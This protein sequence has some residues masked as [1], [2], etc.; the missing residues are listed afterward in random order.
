MYD[1]VD[2]KL[3][4]TH[5]T[6]TEGRSL[7]WK[8]RAETEAHL[9][10]PLR[11]VLNQSEA[12][13][14]TDDHALRSFEKAVRFHNPAHPDLC[15]AHIRHYRTRTVPITSETSVLIRLRRTRTLFQK[16]V[17]SV[18]RPKDVSATVPSVPVQD[19]DIALASLWNEWLDFERVFGSERS[20]D[21]ATLAV[22]KKLR[23]VVPL[24]ESDPRPT[25][26]K[27]DSKDRA[28]KREHDDS[29]EDRHSKKARVE[30][31]ASGG[32]KGMP[33][34]ENEGENNGGAVPDTL[35]AE[36]KYSAHPFTVRVSNLSEVTEDM[37]LVD[38]F[39]SRAGVVVH[40]RIV[41]DKHQHGGKGKSKGWGLVQFEERESVEKALELSGILG[42]H[43]KVINVER[44]HMAAVSVVPPGMHRVQT[45]GEGKSSKR[46]Q[47]RRER[48]PSVVDGE[49]KGQ[50]TRNGQAESEEPLVGAT[51]KSDRLGVLSFRP[52]VVLHSKA[53]PKKKLSLEL[54]KTAPAV[55]SRIES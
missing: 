14:H 20:L 55:N 5:S 12:P 39:R 36:M 4:T 53:K 31:K 27:Q 46:N 41:R 21:Q 48:K 3:R 32:G 15:L 8:E 30:A 33:P 24:I 54:D 52:R 6:W 35:K 44:S 13:S 28:S 17:Q 34:T 51:N 49:S 10:D 47:K 11:R 37:D 38:T 40:A 22:Q 25:T 16:A 1:A 29:D 23:K 2:T 9:L 19:F 45:M 42:L 7:L 26:T 50:S 43:E 18:G